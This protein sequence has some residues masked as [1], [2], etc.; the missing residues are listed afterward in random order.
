MILIL[1]G[2]VICVLRMTSSLKKSSTWGK[3]I[4]H[5]LSISVSVTL[6]RLTLES[7]VADPES[8]STWVNLLGC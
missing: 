3:G 8:E 2:G 5:L 4:Y 6:L 7:V 1:K